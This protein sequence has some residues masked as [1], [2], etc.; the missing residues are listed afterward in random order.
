[1]A[2]II[3]VSCAFAFPEASRLSSTSSDNL[4][5]KGEFSPHGEFSESPS[6]DDPGLEAFNLE[7][8]SFEKM[9]YP[10]VEGYFSLRNKDKEPIVGLKSGDFVLKEDGKRLERFWIHP[11]S[12]KEDALGIVLALDVSGSMQGESLEGLKNAAIAFL[13][14]L[15]RY[16]SVAIVT[17]EDRVSSISGFSTN[18]SSLAEKIRA[19][20]CAGR[21]TELFRAVRESVSLLKSAEFKRKVVVLLSDG[22][23]ESRKQDTS[24]R[25]ILR[26]LPQ[27]ENPRGREIKI[28][29]IGFGKDVREDILKDIADASG[30]KYL[31][32]SEPSNLLALYQ[33]I[34]RELTSQ[35][36]LKI[37]FGS[38]EDDQVHELSIAADIGG[39]I[40]SYRH[41]YTASRIAPPITDCKASDGPAARGALCAIIGTIAG[42][43]L[44]LVIMRISQTKGRPLDLK[45]RVIL[46]IV[47]LSTGLLAGMIL[48]LLQT[49]CVQSAMGFSSP[50]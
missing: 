31:P 16:D 43:F 26:M 1:V 24:L 9:N 20:R 10:I 33:D 15:D 17:F 23:D 48:Y 22:R 40:A 12:S 46:A 8:K 32:V 37:H 19:I 7:L 34:A 47:C 11:V 39:A 28:F 4:A 5:Q 30:G 49:P 3:L 45:K 50:E 21:F 35:Y 18:R 44:F 14:R 6:L 42:M 41:K 29:S 36:Y 38:P 2:W 25:S 13:N 27:T